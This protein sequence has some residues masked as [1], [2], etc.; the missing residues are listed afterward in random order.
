MNGVLFKIELATTYSPTKVGST[1]SA[2]GLNYSVR[3]G[4]RC[5]PAAIITSIFLYDF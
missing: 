4:K 5:D 1:I 3:N 2:G